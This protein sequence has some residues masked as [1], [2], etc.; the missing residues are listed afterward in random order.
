VKTEELIA[1]LAAGGDVVD[2]GSAARRHAG[3]MAVAVLAA[4]LMTLGLLGLQPALP[5]EALIPMFWVREAFCAA[6]AAAGLLGAARLSRPGAPLGL[7]PAAIAASLLILW[8]LAL[9][10]LMVAAPQ[11]RLNLVLG[12]TARVCPFL[13]AM[14]STPLFVAIFR[15]MRSLAPT[16][17]RLAGAAGGFAAG[18]M[19]ALLYTLHCPEL[20]APF[21][22]IWYLLGILMPTALGAVLGPRLLRW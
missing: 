3:A 9:G 19:A 10:Q 2:P 21:L 6:L 20:A 22:G 15:I 14:I 17:L 8:A 7:A 5:S 16:R 4:L 13:I 11:E 12:Q 1:A 18:A